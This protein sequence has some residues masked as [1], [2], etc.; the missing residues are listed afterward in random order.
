MPAYV[1]VDAKVTDPVAYEAYKSLSP[2]AIAAYN[3]RFLS[4]G[5]ATEVLEGDWQP[6][7]I[8]VV[9][10]PDMAAARAFYD[11]PQ[12]LAAREARKDAA[13]FRMIVVEG[14]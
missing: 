12:Y 9:E 8:V 13:E 6:N 4:R 2:A 7:R 1:I 14:L 11:S 10:F 5:G 3:G